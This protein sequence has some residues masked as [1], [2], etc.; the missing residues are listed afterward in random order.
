MPK[1]KRRDTP[2]KQSSRFIETARELGIDETGRSFARA[3]DV[4]L[5]SPTVEGKIRKRK[6][7]T[8]K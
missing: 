4:L 8:E 1:Q 3:V 5:P 7:T 2:A 6:S